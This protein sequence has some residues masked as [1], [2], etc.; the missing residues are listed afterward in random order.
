MECY[1]QGR[2]SEG[3]YLMPWFSLAGKTL[4]K[5]MQFLF[6][7]LLLTVQGSA[8]QDG[9]ECQEY[10][11]GVPAVRAVQRYSNG[12]PRNRDEDV[13]VVLYAPTNKYGCCFLTNDPK[14]PGI[15]PTKFEL[16]PS[17]E[18]R[19]RFRSGFR[20][21]S[22][23]PGT[24]IE[25]AAGEKI[26]LLKLRANGGTPL[27]EY[28]LHGKL[29]YQAVR[30]HKL[31]PAQEVEVL[32]PVNVVSEKSKVEEIDWPFGTHVKRNLIR[33]IALPVEIPA[34]VLLAIA[35]STPKGCDL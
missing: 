18:F 27:G 19:V 29:T 14:Q 6:V 17:T 5:R 34:A 3:G 1:L 20:Y 9:C 25:M 32:I 4:L 22:Q 35:C 21:K 33:I 30:D 28:V 2:K 13:A 16:L 23:A 11:V 15:F 7:L 26:V 12:L 10:R 31:Q 24:P 8:S